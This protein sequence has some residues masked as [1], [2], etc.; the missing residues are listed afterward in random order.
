M[1]ESCGDALY[2]FPANPPNRENRREDAHAPARRYDSLSGYTRTRMHPR[3]PKTCSFPPSCCVSGPFQPLPS[4][5]LLLAQRMPPCAA[6][7]V[8]VMWRVAVL[9]TLG[10]WASQ[11]E[12]SRSAFIRPSVGQTRQCEANT[13]LWASTLDRRADT[14]GGSVRTGESSE[15]LQQRAGRTPL[16]TM[17]IVPG[18]VCPFQQA[19]RLRG[20]PCRSRWLRSG[21]RWNRMRRCVWQ[22]D[23][24]F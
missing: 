8:Q 7:L 16:L 21:R 11:G 4:L 10:C 20:Q 3:P 23:G 12:A 6:F 24:G 18:S 17:T 13:A 22:A 2:P 1:L 5:L 15:F 14:A 9:V 19:A